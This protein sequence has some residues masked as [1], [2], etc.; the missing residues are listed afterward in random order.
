MREKCDSRQRRQ[1][2]TDCAM[3]VHVDVIFNE[4]LATPVL[5][6]VEVKCNQREVRAGAIRRTLGMF[7]KS[8]IGVMV[9]RWP[10]MT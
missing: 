9:S 3:F 2:G 7:T 4:S 1:W 6:D 10:Q 5:V 8:R